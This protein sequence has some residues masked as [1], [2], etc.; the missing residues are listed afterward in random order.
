M[1]NLVG[2]IWTKT[3]SREDLEANEKLFNVISSNY[4]ENNTLNIKVYSQEKPDES[5]IM[6][7]P[8][9]EEVYFVALK[10]DN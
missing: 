5:F 3:I 9:L 2:K 10:N 4:N 1:E 7:Q 8:Q 6:T